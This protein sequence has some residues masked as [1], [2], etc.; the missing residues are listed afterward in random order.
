MPLQAANWTPNAKDSRLGLSPS[1]RWPAGST[2]ACAE[3]KQRPI[4]SGC[5]WNPWG[6]S[7]R[8]AG[9]AQHFQ[10]GPMKTA[11]APPFKRHPRG[12]A[13]VIAETPASDRE[14]GDALLTLPDGW[15]W[16]APDGHQQFG[17]FDS[18]ELARAD[19]ARGSVESI[20]DDSAIRQM[21]QVAGIAGFADVETETSREDL[22]SLQP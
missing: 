6:L 22:D 20:E 8:K 12:A 10:N 3:V 21:E 1:P 13:R 15:Y 14:N 19:R 7:L 16:L 4:P 9:P 5:S 17:P 2:G 18:A 11:S